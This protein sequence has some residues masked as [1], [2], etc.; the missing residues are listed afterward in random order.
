MDIEDLEAI[1]MLQQLAEN[2][3]IYTIYME[4]GDLGK[5]VIPYRSLN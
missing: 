1:D 5:V 4:N 3:V 2:S